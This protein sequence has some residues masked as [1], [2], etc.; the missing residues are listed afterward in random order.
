MLL[1]LIAGGIWLYIY[2]LRQSVDPARILIKTVITIVLIIGAGLTIVPQMKTGGFNAVFGIFM[3]LVVGLIIALIWRGHITDLMARPFENLFTGGSRPPDPEPFYS[4]ART[5]RQQQRFD[6]AIDEIGLQLEQFP[7]DFNGLMFMAEIQ[8]VNLHNLTGA[9]ETID[10]ICRA[11]ADAPGKIF[12]AL[13]ALADWQLQIGR[14]RDAALA[15]FERVCKLFPDHPVATEALQ[16]IAHLPNQEMLDY[17]DGPRT[18]ELKRMPQVVIRERSDVKVEVKEESPDDAIGRLVNHLEMHP[19]DRASREELA[20]LYA[21]HLRDAAPAAGQL[22]M[23]IRQPG[24]DRKN[25][26]KWLN[27]LADY[28]LQIDGD[29]P[30]AERALQRIEQRFPKTPAAEMA[31]RR[32]ATLALELK[33]NEK[34]RDVKLGSYER[35]MGL[36]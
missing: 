27:R 19:Q 10:R 4:V 14:N 33:G 3:T 17:Q 1:G 15:A 28:H 12:G 35:D 36:R 34:S 29:L 32:R 7:E 5:K 9:T 31:A 20:G 18:I 25:V 22:E 23:L 21:N 13:T 8:A 6:E 30:A 11:H 26:V 2:L 16:R 24:H